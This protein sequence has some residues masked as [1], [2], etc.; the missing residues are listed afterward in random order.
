MSPAYTNGAE[1]E[2]PGAEADDPI[3]VLAP[4]FEMKVDRQ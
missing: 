1:R 2:F 4:K 3:G